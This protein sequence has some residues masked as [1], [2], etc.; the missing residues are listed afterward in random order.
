[1]A[2][3]KMLKNGILIAVLVGA[4]VLVSG[5]VSSEGGSSATSSQT[6][7][8]DITEEEIQLELLATATHAG[9][10]AMSKNWDADAEDDGI[11]VY[12][13]LKDENDETVKFE[14][15][16]LDVDIEIWTTEFDENFDEVKDRLVYTGTGKIDSWKDGNFMFKGGI[17]V[18]FDD[19]TTVQSDDD[20]GLLLVKI[21]TPDDLSFE[22]ESGFARIQPD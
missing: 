20:Y 5:C 18:S 2:N 10:D 15:I 9:V 22:A 7:V 13:E 14:G 11:I 21:H 3:E 6:G 17:K 19:M 4:L 8:P 1:M 16:E 12:P